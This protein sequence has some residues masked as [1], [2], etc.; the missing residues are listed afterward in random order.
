MLQCYYSVVYCRVRD[1][2]PWLGVYQSFA[3]FREKF[4]ISAAGAEFFRNLPH[5]A[6]LASQAHAVHHVP[7]LSMEY[8]GILSISCHNVNERAVG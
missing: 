6:P 8:F 4:A 7:D 3:I 1:R 5:T 2:V